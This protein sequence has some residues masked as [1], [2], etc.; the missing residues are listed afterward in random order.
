M[1]KGTKTAPPSQEWLESE[2]WRAW[3]SIGLTGLKGSS[4]AYLLAL[5][6]E[7]IRG[8]FLIIVPRLQ[9]AESLLE[10]LRF[11]QK[12]EKLAPL[13]FPPWETL[14]YDKIAPHPEIIQERVKCL[15]SLLKGEQA[16]FIAPIGALM[17]KVLSPG[18]FE[19]AT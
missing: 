5:W 11:F 15:F 13:P 1:A 7:R 10:D 6:R 4:K 17:R 18:H 3:K 8:P 16:A 19:G 14:P 2:S 9:D 12:D